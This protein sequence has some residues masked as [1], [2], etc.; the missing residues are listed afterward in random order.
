MHLFDKMYEGKVKGLF[1]Y[2]TDPAV[3]SP[4]SNKV[5]KA[6]EKLD[7]EGAAKASK[8][9]ERLRQSLNKARSL[10]RVGMRA[11][12]LDDI[13]RGAVKDPAVIREAVE[14]AS[15]ELK[16]LEKLSREAHPANR[17]LLKGILNENLGKWA[18]MRGT[19]W[20][21]ANK[22]PADKL[23]RGLHGFYAFLR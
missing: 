11:D 10:E 7:T 16:L 19:F 17:E 20:K 12:Y 6:L 23:L 2:G 1:S 14:R 3:S 9:V 15:N 21:Y 5:R 22:V 13:A 18:Q 8:H 4:N